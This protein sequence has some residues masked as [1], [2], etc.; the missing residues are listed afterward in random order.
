VSD[1][2]CVMAAANEELLERYR[3]ENAHLERALR[4]ACNDVERWENRNLD[5]Y[6]DGIS[7]EEIYNNYLQKSKVSQ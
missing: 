4:L 5:D 7:V 2:C 1:W 3:K 6:D